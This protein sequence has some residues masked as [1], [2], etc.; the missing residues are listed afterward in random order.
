MKQTNTQTNSNTH[1]HKMKKTNSMSL[2]LIIAGIMMCS[3]LFKSDALAGPKGDILVRHLGNIDITIDGSISDWPLNKFEKVSQ[4]PLF[5]QAQESDT[6]GASGDHIVF[7]RDRIGR[8][9]GTGEN[10]W[11]A[12]DSD[13]GSTV[14]F[15]HNDDYLYMLAVFIDDIYRMDRD[16]TEHGTTGFLNDGFEFFLD[17]RNNSDDC[18]SEIQ[19]PIF[20][21][22]EPNVDDFQL[23]VGLNE[24]FKPEGSP[25]DVL[26]A[27]QTIERGGD[28][29]LIGPDKGGPGGIYRDALD[30]VP[31]VDI[32]ARSFADLRAAGALNPE[33]LANPNIT[34][35]GYTVEMLMPFGKFTAFTPDHSMGFELFWRDVDTDDDE[36][37]GG[38]HQ[39]GDLGAEH[40]G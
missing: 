18:A 39:L 9:N 22:E 25:D 17:T 30:A 11:Q 1:R 23:T 24:N 21:P 7:N 37:K 15:A 2:V 26:G 13:F 31:G 35:S 20:D 32:A 12:G 34:Y 14:Y 4:Q 6:T 40:H 38:E 29:E 5:P 8:F 33:I 36:G 19:F 10:A 3:I 16:A 28:P 27:R